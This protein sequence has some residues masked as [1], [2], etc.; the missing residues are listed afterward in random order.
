MF[1]TLYA[2]ITW[3]R[4]MGIFS[5]LTNGEAP[6]ESSALAVLRCKIIKKR[7]YKEE[8]NDF[9]FLIFLTT[10]RPPTITTG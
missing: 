7:E 9:S 3:F 6:R 2:S 10:T 1:I 5:A 8:K 4:L